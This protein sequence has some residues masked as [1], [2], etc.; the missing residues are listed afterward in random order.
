MF[1]PEIKVISRYVQ[2]VLD[3]VDE[4]ENVDEEVDT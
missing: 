2:G 1:V 4:E 3:A